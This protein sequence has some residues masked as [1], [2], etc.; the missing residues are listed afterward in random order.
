[1]TCAA[2]GVP[3]AGGTDPSFLVKSY[4]LH[5]SSPWNTLWPS[6]GL[7]SRTDTQ[8][9][10]LSMEVNGAALWPQNTNLPVYSADIKPAEAGRILTK[11][12]SGFSE[13]YTATTKVADW[14][15]D[16]TGRQYK[17]TAVLRLWVAPLSGTDMTGKGITL[18]AQLFKESKTSRQP[19]ASK[20]RFTNNSVPVASSPTAS[21]WSCGGWQEVWFSL[22]VDTTKFPLNSNEYIGVR[23]WNPGGSGMLEDVRLAYDVTG[24]FVATLAIPEK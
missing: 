11:T 14:R 21:T 18:N 4:V 13:S 7:D 12:T 19:S 17:G 3:L 6:N 22:D 20:L 2:S 10:P 8:Q 1:M 15:S 9:L 16:V 5:N 24:D 23:V